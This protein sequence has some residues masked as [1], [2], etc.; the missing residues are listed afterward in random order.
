MLSMSITFDDLA[1][2]A[3]KEFI[4]TF[5]GDVNDIDGT[6]VLAIID[7]VELDDDDDDNRANM[8]YE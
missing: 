1:P 4:E 7:R 8:E 6:N 2:H 3:Q 5:G